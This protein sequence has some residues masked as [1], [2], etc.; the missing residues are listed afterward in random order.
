[1]D[2]TRTIR[3]RSVKVDASFVNIVEKSDTLVALMGTF[4]ARRGPFALYTDLVAVE[5]VG[6]QA[7][8]AFR[9]RPFVPIARRLRYGCGGRRT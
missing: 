6:C 5:A 8:Q 1:M 9:N 7:A 2:G 4:E 3:G